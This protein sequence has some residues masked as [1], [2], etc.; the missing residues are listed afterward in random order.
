MNTGTDDFLKMIDRLPN[1]EII[2][3]PNNKNIVMAAE[4]AARMAADSGKT[5]RVIP[6]RTIPQG[7]A[8]L[9]NYIS[10]RETAGL[11]EIVEAM[12][13][14]INEVVTCEITTATRDVE[15]DGVKVIAGQYIGLVDGQLRTSGAMLDQVVIDTLTKARADEYELITLYYGQ[16]LAEHQTQALVD[17]LTITFAG[18]EFHLV[19]GGQPL[20]PYLISLE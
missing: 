3:L 15:I 12:N 7:I 9:V 1:D 4:Q 5:V 6:T 13:E 16:Q 19:Y 20:Y 8:S 11:D 10:L 14:A 2:L 18:Q 17:H